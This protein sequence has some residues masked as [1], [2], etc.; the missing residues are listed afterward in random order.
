MKNDLINI[1]K[2]SQ[3][4]VHQLSNGIPLSMYDSEMVVLDMLTTELLTSLGY[5][6]SSHKELQKA[7]IN[8]YMFGSIQDKIK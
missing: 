3:E 6:V 2:R 5:D 4:I 1:T 8:M 7:L